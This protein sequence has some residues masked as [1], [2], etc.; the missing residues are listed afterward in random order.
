MPN[1]AFEPVGTIITFPTGFDAQ[2]VDISQDIEV[3]DINVSHFQSVDYHEFIAS[4]LMDAG[5]V[6]MTIHFNPAIDIAAHLRADG[7]CT[8][9]WIDKDGINRG[10]WSFSGYMRSYSMSGS[11]GEAMTADVSIKVNGE[12]TITPGDWPVSP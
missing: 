9:Q 11:I 12:I 7:T 2:I 1:Y 6:S 3:E 5:E 10:T 8:I 4:A